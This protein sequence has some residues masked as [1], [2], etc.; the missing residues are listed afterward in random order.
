MT[1]VALAQTEAL[2]RNSAT[3]HS[4]DIL[5]RRRQ[6]LTLDCLPVV[7]TYLPPTCI[8]EPYIL[9]PPSCVF[10]CILGFYADIS[11]QHQ[12]KQ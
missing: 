6:H 9:P 12:M 8:M 11:N 7:I 4:S 1:V 10:K 5:H 2:Y 3:H